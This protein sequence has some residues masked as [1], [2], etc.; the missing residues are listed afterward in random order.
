MRISDDEQNYKDLDWY[1]VDSDGRVG[2]FTSAGFKR[3]PR[4]VSESSADLEFLHQFFSTLPGTPN[5]HD[6]DEHLTPQQ[7]SER[8]LHSFVEMA[9]R[10]LFSFDIE[11]YPTPDT[12]YFRVAVPK[13]PLRFADLPEGVRD[14]LSRTALKDRSFEQCTKIPYSETLNL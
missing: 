11:T 7:R 1:C 9:D 6:L 13:Q 2:H 8:Y 5:A 4:S 12:C 3:V 10:G 14:V